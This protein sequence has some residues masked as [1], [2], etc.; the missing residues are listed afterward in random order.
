MSQVSQVD[1]SFAAAVL[2]IPGLDLDIVTL[3]APTLAR[4][5]VRVKMLFSGVCRSQLLEARGQRGEDP[6]L[7]HLLGHEGVGVVLEVGAGV[8][9]V[10][11][12]DRVIVGWIKGSGIDSAAPA[13]TTIDGE[14]INAGPVTTFAEQTVVSENRVYLKP[15][16]LTDRVAALFGCALLTGAGMVL[17]E[18]RPTPGESVLIN[19]LGGVGLSALVATIGLGAAVFVVDPDPRK[20]ETALELGAQAAMSPSDL[21]SGGALHA[22]PS[23]GVDIAIDASGTTSGIEAAF[24]CLRFGGGRLFFASHPP[25]GDRICLD[26]LDLIRGRR[27]HGSWGGGS[28]PDVDIPRL[29]EAVVKSGVALDFMVPR[30]YELSEI[31]DALADLEQNEAMR[32]L[33][34]LN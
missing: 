20:Q 7:P 34:R 29:A 15:E 12:G 32:P 33:I 28:S 14:Q 10:V 31:N 5:Q 11:P 6:W 30:T 16:A 21:H 22:L 2:R 9:K 27:I 1:D 13:F 24:E 19:G 18:A 17:N 3:T 23:H 26:P 25:S 4:G 8:S